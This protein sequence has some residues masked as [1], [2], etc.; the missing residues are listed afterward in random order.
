[1][2]VVG[3]IG[4]K[5]IRRLFVLKSKFFIMTII[6]MCVLSLVSCKNSKNPDAIIAANTELFKEKLFALDYEEKS[7]VLDYMEEPIT[8]LADT[9][10]TLYI[11]EIKE[12]TVIEHDQL[13]FILSITDDKG[14]NYR[15]FLDEGLLVKVEKDDELIFMLESG[16]DNTYIKRQREK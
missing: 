6:F 1:M 8:F 7:R 12:V 2:P 16:I 10:Y 15:L 3:L 11:D 13:N 4:I 14:D 9:L 5:N